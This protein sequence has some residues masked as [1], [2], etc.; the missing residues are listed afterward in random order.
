[1]P[2]NR[3]SRK[4]EVELF[5]AFFRTIFDAKLETIRKATVKVGSKGRI[6]LV[7]RD[8]FAPARKK[9]TKGVFE[10][11]S[12]ITRAFLVHWF[13][14]PSGFQI[15]IATSL[16]KEN[17]SEILYF[18]V[19]CQFHQHFTC[20]FFVRMLFRQLFCSYMHVEKAAETM[21]VRKMLMKLTPVQEK[22]SFSAKKFPGG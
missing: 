11:T 22:I 3:I 7:Q 19:R 15:N 20:K 6:K 16:D 18:E 2:K 9:Q 12:L 10:S 5:Q 13:L 17:G 1:L 8:C 4:K 21:F 14:S